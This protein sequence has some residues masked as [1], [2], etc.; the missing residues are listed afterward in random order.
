MKS[1]FKHTSGDAFTLDGV[2]YVGY[3]N[4]T[5]NLPYTGRKKTTE[6][7]LL[8]SKNNNVSQIYSNKIEFDTTYRHVSPIVN[9]YSNSFDILNKQG[10]SNMLGAVDKN[11]LT[12]FRNLI[13][14]RPTI[15]KFEETGGHFFG[16]SSISEENLNSIVPKYD[17]SNIIP[18]SQTNNFKFLDKIH[19]STFLVDSSDNFKYICA[20]DEGLYTFV[21]NFI[22]SEGLEITQNIK[23][24]PYYN[25]IHKIFHDQQNNKFYIVRNDDI[26]IYDASNYYDCD[27]LILE[28]LINLPYKSTTKEY[29]WD[30]TD[31]AFDELFVT[32]DTKYTTTNP[33][34]VEYVKFGYN[35]RTILEENILKLYNKYS[36]D[37]IKSIDLSN[38]N[39][40]NVVDL[41][42]RDVDDYIT[43][44]YK[45]NGDYRVSFIDSEDLS[46]EDYALYG[47]E[48]SDI[49]NISFV[50]NDSNLI[51]VRNG[52]EFQYRC[53][54][55]PEYPCGR[56]DLN[57]LNYDFTKYVWDTTDQ[58]WN[59]FMVLWEGLFGDS[60]QYN[61]LAVSTLFKDDKMYAILH[62]IGR[63]YVL[64]QSMSDQYLSFVPMGLSKYY[65]GVDT[66]KHSLGLS[67]NL[68]I[69]NILKDTLNLFNQSSSS[70]T[71]K[72]RGIILDKIEDF[73]LETENLYMNGNETANVVMLQRILLLITQI[74]SKLLPKT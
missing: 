62:N 65:S 42:I 33:N 66:A 57:D 56:L 51:S 59:F 3:F 41:D 72:E 20:D 44:L 60:N 11:N 53:I 49:Q 61:N 10:L 67:F 54:S 58:V 39:I 9:Y 16:L 71:L 50:Y 25:V 69:S 8:S 63:I 34:N 40:S 13:I 1:Y 14:Q 6:S 52:K 4:I 32:F 7:E 15:F 24:S 27:K 70:F 48:K 46:S 26:S 74:Q 43:I 73:V 30:T 2:D 68:M 31:I 12:C 18:F 22:S 38:Y 5:D 23:N 35:Y 45:Q 64:N 19:T 29:I 21:G 17:I 55:A 28:D 36:L 37:L 47:L